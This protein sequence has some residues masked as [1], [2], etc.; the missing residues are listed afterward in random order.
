MRGREQ[1]RHRLETLELVRP[2][3]EPDGLGVERRRRQVERDGVE[4]RAVRDRLLLVRDDLLRDRHPAE[5]ELEPESPLDAK[6]LLDRRLRLLLRLRVPVALERL[7][8]RPP[9]YEVQLANEELAGEKG[10]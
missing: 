7:D 1:E 8:E 10:G 3:H 6:R 5:G 2:R 9:C 4:R